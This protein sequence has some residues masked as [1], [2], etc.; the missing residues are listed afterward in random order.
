[1]R[2][3]DLEISEG[4]AEALEAVGIE[5]LY[6]PQ[7]E[8]V[9]AGLLEG[10]SLLVTTP[11]ASGKTLLAVLAADRW[12]LEGRK[13]VYLTPLRALAYEKAEFL[14]GLLGARTVTASG[15]YDEEAAYL[16]RYEVIVA[17]YE[18]MDSAI[19][20]G[21]SWLSRVGLLVVDEAHLIADQSRGATVEVLLARLQEL[22]PD[23][24][25]R[26]LLSATVTNA[27]QIATCFGLGLVKSSWRPT[28]LVEA[29]YDARSSSLVRAD[30]SRER[31][32]VLDADPSVSLALW[33]WG[34][35]G[36]AMIYASAR[37]VAEALA[38]HAAQTIY[39][40]GFLATSD[41]RALASEL[42]GTELD[43][44]LRNLMLRGAAFHHA[45]LSPQQRRVVEA[46]FRSRLL[47]VIVATPTLAAGVN[48]PA[49]LVVVPDVRRGAEDLSVMDYK[50]LAGRA[51]RPGYDEEGLAVIVSRS[52]AKTREL[53]DRYVRGEP[54]PVGSRLL[55]LRSL[56]FHLLGM[57][58]SGVQDP[59]AINSFMGRTL[60][61]RQLGPEAMSR[62]VRDSVAWLEAAGMVRRWGPSR[63]VA[64]R[65]GRRVAELYIMPET[66][67]ILL[68]EMRGRLATEGD[69]E[70]WDLYALYAICSTPDVPE[71]TGL[72][73]PIM[74]EAVPEE[75]SSR[76]SVNALLKS[77]VLRAWVME[78]SEN[79]I[80]MRYNAAPGD[81]HVL[82]EAA[83]WIARSAGQLALVTGREGLFRRFEELSKRLEHGVRAELLPLVSVPGVG[84]VRARVL[85]NAG[86]RRPEDLA[87][88]GEEALS[89]LPTIGVETARRI[90]HYINNLRRGG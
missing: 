53:L 47:P 13:V 55:D 14:E 79:Q 56:R 31:V 44:R 51:G 50:Q 5:E 6:P 85:Y 87:S 64:T 62:A 2:V 11:T 30:G 49:R 54:E 46:A 71:V 19:R 3:R 72:Q 37:R 45:G 23:D 86:L 69:P 24:G 4:L 8:A 38:E 73:A 74:E 48:I 68:R 35:G 33:A 75:L 36:Q 10:R 7:A 59:A 16:G 76:G 57:I 78:E 70:L 42:G 1:L 61:A 82:A 27:E 9:R 80:Y 43:E 41:L 20:H 81:L 83:A 22:L 25:Q 34:R 40:R 67:L 18:K 17:T 88:V 66:A 29:V 77:L 15:D 90:A 39:R 21:A 58:A 89:R 12:L 60:A 26:L 28:R 65:V 52:P 32:P 63:L 84:R